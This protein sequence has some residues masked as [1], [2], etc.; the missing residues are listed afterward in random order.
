MRL[1]LMIL[2]FGLTL[3]SCGQAPEPPPSAP[4]FEKSELSFKEIKTTIYIPELYNIRKT[5]P[6]IISLHGWLNNPDAHNRMFKLSDLVDSH[7]FIY[8]L[9]EPPTLD[10]WNFSQPVK[11]LDFLIGELRRKYSIDKN[12][13]YLV[14][15]SAGARAAY[16]YAEHRDQIAGL[17]IIGGDGSGPK[18]PT[19]VIHIHGEDDYIVPYSFGEITF[20]RYIKANGCGNTPK[21]SDIRTGFLSM[22]EERIYHGC[23]DGKLTAFYS[24]KETGHY[25]RMGRRFVKHVTNMML[26]M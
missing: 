14:G 7:K 4:S 25:P 15:H 8:A 12:R 17:I 22:A 3:L 20:N 9:P 19:N 16:E 11:N 5:Y 13:I 23:T 26:K 24:F 18:A 1:R 10:A 6:L 2:S 21:R